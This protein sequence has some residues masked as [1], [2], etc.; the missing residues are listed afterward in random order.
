MQV[1]SAVENLNNEFLARRL[2]LADEQKKKLAKIS[3]DMEAKRSELRAAMRDQDQR[4]EAFQK[5]RQVRGDAD[6]QA[7]AVL[8]PEQKDNYEEM[9]G[10]KIELEFRRGPR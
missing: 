3:K 7:L 2:E 4:A 8:T 9:K 5:F 1:T 10:E 6:K